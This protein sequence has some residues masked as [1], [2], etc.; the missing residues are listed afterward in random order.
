MLPAA[1]KVSHTRL[2][3]DVELTLR[4]CPVLPTGNDTTAPVEFIVG[5]DPSP[6]SER[7]NPASVNTIP[8]LES[9]G[10]SVDAVPTD[11]RCRLRRRRLP[12]RLLRSIL[13]IWLVFQIKM[14]V[15]LLDESSAVVIGTYFAAVEIVPPAVASPLNSLQERFPLVNIVQLVVRKY[16][17]PLLVVVP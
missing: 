10:K 4:T 13:K 3:D 1:G 14:R 11:S 8:P 16:L 12:D 2:V 15:H 7:D 17:L 5:N 6:V 9:I